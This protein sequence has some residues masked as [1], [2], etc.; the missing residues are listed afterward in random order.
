MF[1]RRLAVPLRKRPP[2]HTFLRHVNTETSENEA[3]RQMM[4]DVAIIE[5]HK[6]FAAQIDILS[7]LTTGKYG[8]LQRPI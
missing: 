7:G 4:A 6:K 2:I 3:R 8:C 5:N 1:L